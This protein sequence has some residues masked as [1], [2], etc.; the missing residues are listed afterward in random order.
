MKSPICV[1]LSCNPDRVTARLRGLRELGL[2]VQERPLELGEFGVPAIA[3][4]VYLSEGESLESVVRRAIL[5]PKLD[6]IDDE[7]HV[8]GLLQSLIP[9][10]KIAQGRCARRAF[11]ILCH[12]SPPVVAT[13]EGPWGDTRAIVEIP[14]F[15]L[16]RAI[17]I[18]SNEQSSDDS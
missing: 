1:G 4:Y 12:A 9:W 17:E 6:E 11:D 18:L 7:G 5:S 13:L 8:Y 2:E 10:V 15:E 16:D 3:I 14:A